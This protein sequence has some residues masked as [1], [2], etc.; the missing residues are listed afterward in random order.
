[1]TDFAHFVQCS[2]CK[3]YDFLERHHCKSIFFFKHEYWGDE[4]QKIYASTFK[5]AAKEFARKYNESGDYPLMDGGQE[6]VI[7]SD[8][9]TEKTFIVRVE[10]AIDYY[11][12]EKETK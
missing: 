4:F 8:G 9:K 5:D 10:Q 6:E 1:M 3:K 2:T 12:D 7:I 11:A